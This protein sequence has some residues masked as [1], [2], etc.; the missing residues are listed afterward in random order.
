MKGVREKSLSFLV[1]LTA[2]TSLFSGMSSLSCRCPNGQEKPFCFG[3]PSEKTS[4]CC[5]GSCCS[6]NPDSMTV[7]TGSVCCCCESEQKP[8]EP[9]NETGF[10]A[11]VPC[12]SKT[13]SQAELTTAPEPIDHR[14]DGSTVIVKVMSP[15]VSIPQS[16]IREVWEPFRVPPPTDLVT[17]LQHLTI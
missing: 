13:L 17:L 8:P 3:V 12:C 7:G 16:T 9:C 6:V 15:V 1:W 5:G 11:N 10:R 2:S 4:C 14:D